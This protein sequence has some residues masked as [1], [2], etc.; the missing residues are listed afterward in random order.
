MVLF[1][2]K[3][4]RTKALNECRPNVRDKLIINTNNC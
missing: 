4:N 1:D 3:K 2:I